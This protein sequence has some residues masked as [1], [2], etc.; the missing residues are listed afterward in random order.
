MPLGQRARFDRSRLVSFWRGWT[1]ILALVGV[2][3]LLAYV[4]AYVARP[5]GADG[6]AFLSDFGEV[7]VELIGVTLGIAIVA[8]E[9]RPQARLAWWLVTIALAANLIGNVVYGIYDQAG[10]QPFPSIADAFYLGFYPL[11]LL[12]LL[13]L[14]TASLR[15]D[16]FAWRVW[17]NV[18]IVILGG[19]MALVHFVLLPTVAQ[20]SGEPVTTLVSLAYPAGDLALVT[21][22]ATI[23]SRRPYAGDR[24]VLALFMLAV[25]AWFVADLVFAILSAS[26][27]YE[28][29]SISDVIWLA[30]D[31]AFVLAAQACLVSMPRKDRDTPGEVL[32]IG[33]L[34]P[35][36]MLGLGLL[37]LVAAT[38]G[39]QREIAVLAILV[40]LLTALV[41]FRQLVDESQRRR[42]EAALLA[43]RS[44][45]A[46]RAARQARHDSLTS[47]PNRIRVHEL[48]QGEIEASRLTGR[49][50]TLGF[51]DLNYFKAVN[52]NFGHAVGDELLVEVSHRL[53]R[54]VR[55]GDTV[56]RLGGDEFAV[57][58]PDLADCDV[59]ALA[60][61]VA[62]SVG[63][64]YLL[65]GRELFVAASV[66]VAVAADNESADTLL[67]NA[68]LAMYRAKR[69]GLGRHHRYHTGM[70]EAIIDRVAL[71]A[72][73]HHALDRNELVLHYQPTI[74]LASDA[75]V[76][77]EALIR[78]RHPT[79]GL[80]PPAR[81]IPAAE[82]SALIVELGR[83]AL[84]EA[85]AQM[86]RWR[87]SGSL[88]KLESI[89]VNISGRHLRDPAIVDDVRDAVARS[90]LPPTF[91]VIEIT[92]GV[93]VE[94]IE[95]N[96]QTLDALKRLGVRIALD[97]FGTGYS[98]LNY[99]HRFPIDILK[100]DQ[101]FLQNLHRAQSQS[102]AR[103]II[104]LGQAL[105]LKT[106]AEGVETVDQLH[107][108]KLAGCSQAQ[109]FHL[110]PPLESSQAW[111]AIHAH[112]M[113]PA[114]LSAQLH[115]T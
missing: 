49:P 101:S 18:V 5:A 33:R 47:L 115:R 112:N 39:E 35:Y 104:R 110:C 95:Q 44:A 88:V 24:G 70:R 58:I 13:A 22:I 31:L 9:P 55:E 73:L 78:W 114:G 94:Q 92:E 113:T 52:D 12:G 84:Q 107:A 41:V 68:D 76:G 74:D 46:D 48:L 16:L 54:S 90:G 102:L 98:A 42:A 64:R 40:V 36:A 86:T 45:A 66:G 60:D 69:L 19:G 83:W 77:A 27:S 1:G 96:R 21:A 38:L 61:R 80:L 71:E 87:D 20:L 75:V 85:C 2:A 3:S 15:R 53:V 65:Q 32:S 93:L 105:A 8:R 14:P 79:R 111:Q 30:G 97:D 63:E 34:G 50:V 4:W 43:E 17:S 100:I 82:Q 72:E 23:S 89:A 81:F 56:A 29:G 10:Q 7:P 37:T 108:I 57:I 62:Q 25:G 26:A 103:A 106:I 67:S 99:L 11:M 51:L 28:Q 91:L 59:E 109:G 6:A